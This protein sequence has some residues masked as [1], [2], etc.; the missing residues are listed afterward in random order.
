MSCGITQE[1]CVHDELNSTNYK[2]VWV[3]VSRIPH[4]SWSVRLTEPEPP[5]QSVVGHVASKW[6]PPEEALVIQGDII[7]VVLQHHISCLE[8]KQQHSRTSTSPWCRTENI[9]N[10]GT[11]TIPVIC[12]GNFKCQCW[13]ISNP[14]THARTHTHLQQLLRQVKGWAERASLASERLSLVLVNRF[15][16]CVAN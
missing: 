10:I 4:D 14:D 12:W 13:F 1:I 2:A 5:Q 16:F 3:S 15:L 6:A 8:D 7:G 11:G 9:E